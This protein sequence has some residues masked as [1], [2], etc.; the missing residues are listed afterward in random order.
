MNVAVEQTAP[1]ETEQ[2]AKAR[3][4]RRL[5]YTASGSLAAIALLAFTS[6]WLTTGRYLETT[7]DAYV[8]A[9][10]VALS[11]RVAGYVA[12]VAVAD[13]QPVK[14]GDVLVRLQNRDYRARLDQAR[15]G[16]AEAQAALVAAQ[17]RQ[18]VASERI[19]QQQ[20]AILQAEAAM[21]SATAEQRRSDLDMQRYRGLVRDE[22]A[23]VQ[24]LETASAKAT[25]AKAALQGAQAA[26]REQRSQLAITK[27]LSAQADA[28][29]QQRAAALT[30]A[31]ARQQLAEQDEQDTVIRAPIT[32][33]V[34][35]RRVRAGQYVVPGQP[36]LAVVPLQQAYVVANFK[37]TQ[38][39]NMRPGQPVEIRVDSFASQ[40]L[41][42]HV[43]SFS[44]ASGNVFALLPS[45]NAT[46]NF[47]KIVQRFPV[48]ILLDTPLDGPQVLPGMSVVSTVDTR[49]AEVAD[50]Q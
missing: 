23:T 26:L 47:T 50:A 11:P 34:G 18:Q 41:R 43:A 28:E 21:R 3:S 25:Q 7:D 27:G 4:R 2:R 40:P 12:E 15:A 49:P 1:A 22:A 45:D 31:Q 36:L 24:R 17:A 13:D 32:G 19:N 42:G 14:A 44:P 10:W 20:Q 37:E 6:Y 33:V 38:L 5:A 46:G 9:D 30:R 8:R 35:Q 16:V 48:R 29:L 39:A